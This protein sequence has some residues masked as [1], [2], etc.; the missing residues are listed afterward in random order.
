MKRTDSESAYV[1]ERLCTIGAQF[2]HCLVWF[3]LI[4]L[5]CST[6][7]YLLTWYHEHV[8]LFVWFVCFLFEE[9]RGIAGSTHSGY[10]FFRSRI[11]LITF[12]FIYTYLLINILVLQQGEKQDECLSLSFYFCSLR[13]GES[14]FILLEMDDFRILCCG[15]SYIFNFVSALYH[16]QLNSFFW[17]Q[18]S[19]LGILT[20]EENNLFTLI[21]GKPEKNNN[22]NGNMRL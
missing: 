2:Q 21:V 14:L 6:C 15:I 22:K 7:L 20:R 19:L 16:F 17:F 8:F 4:I 3:M 12:S 9:C 5:L 11:A 1:F 13:T 18:K 10:H